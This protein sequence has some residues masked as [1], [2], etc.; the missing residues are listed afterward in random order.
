MSANQALIVG[1][2]FIAPLYNAKRKFKENIRPLNDYLLQSLPSWNTQ[3]AH[4]GKVITGLML[5]KV[6][7]CI[8][9][10][11]NKGWTFHTLGLHYEY[12][13]RTIAIAVLKNVHVRVLE[14]HPVQVK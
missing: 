5:V 4:R 12:Y 6:K 11:K 3:F 13:E 1:A 7:S 2:R 10:Q 8:D 14:K 9:N